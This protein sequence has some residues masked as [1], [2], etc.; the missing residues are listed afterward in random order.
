MFGFVPG[1]K[2]GRTNLVAGYTNGK[3]MAECAQE[4]TMDGVFFNA[5]VEQFLVPA[6]K[7]GQVVV[8]DNASFHK[9]QTTKE[10]IDSADCS[11]IFLPSYSPNLNPIENSW[12]NFKRKLC[13]ILPLSL[14]SLLLFPICTSRVK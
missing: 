10:L 1:R 8:I 6:L 9:S 11:L 5:W 7:P 2:F 4:G 3:S 13:N 14:L 12:P